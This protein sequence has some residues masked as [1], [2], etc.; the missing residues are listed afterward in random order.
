M[1]ALILAAALAYHGPPPVT[2]LSAVREA[3]GTVT[4]SWT[5]PTSTSVVG[6]TIDRFRIDDGHHDL[7]IF[8]IV[9]ITSLY[10]DAS[11]ISHRGYRYWVY[12]RDASG[13]LS[14]GEVVDVFSLDPD[15]HHSYSS[16]DCHGSVAAAPI[17]GWPLLAALAALLL[18]INQRR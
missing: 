4:L 13:A 7:D 18:L 11:A 1:G 3:D 5:L 10:P 6:V 12:T 2:G 8:E 14:V 9:G 16:F 17:R 15:D